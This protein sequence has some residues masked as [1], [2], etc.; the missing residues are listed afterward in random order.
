MADPALYTYPDPL[1]G[2]EGLPPLPDERNADGKSYVNPPAASLSPA[3]ERFTAPIDNGVRGGFDVHIYFYQT[4]PAQVEYAT[5][6]WERVRREFPELR[7]YALFPRPIGPHLV[8]MFEVNLFTPAQF[9][10]FVAWLVVHRGPL[11]ALVHPNTGDD[12]RDHT[13]RATWL[14]EPMPLN[15]ALFY[16]LE[17]EK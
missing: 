8:G 3:Y 11:S 17:E 12:L 7:T 13:Q 16:R 10:A 15:T 2:F 14:G 5:R 9:G 6:L 4:D 1:E